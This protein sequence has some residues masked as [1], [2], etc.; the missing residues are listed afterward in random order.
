MSQADKLDLV[1]Q[2]LFVLHRLQIGLNQAVKVSDEVLTDLRHL[3]TIGL[4]LGVRLVLYRT[5]IGANAREV[6]C[7]CVAI[8]C[9]RP[10]RPRP[11]IGLGPLTSSRTKAEPDPL[12]AL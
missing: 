1:L 4:H 6:A 2:S 3:R 12:L 8:S 11:F 5:A 9:Q 10:L 7:P